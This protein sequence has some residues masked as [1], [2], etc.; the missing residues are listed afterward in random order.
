M[1]FTP[2]PVSDQGTSIDISSSA[3]AE[4]GYYRD[5]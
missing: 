2:G 3:G 5:V 4:D 1:P